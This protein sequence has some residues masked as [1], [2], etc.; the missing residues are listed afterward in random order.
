M[1]LSLYVIGRS[2]FE[3]GSQVDLVDSVQDRQGYA[4]GPP[5]FEQLCDVPMVEDGLEAIKG[6]QQTNAQKQ[7]VAGRE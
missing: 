4:W 7:N 6:T 3:G 1:K 2:R 5:Y